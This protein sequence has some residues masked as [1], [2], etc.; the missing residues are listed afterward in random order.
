MNR[1][2]SIILIC[3]FILSGCG[4]AESDKKTVVTTV[5][6]PYDFVKQIAGDSID[7]K[8]L[9]KPGGDLHSYEPTPQDIKTISECDL[10]ICTGGENDSWAKNIIE[11]SENKNILTMM[12]CVD[13]IKD[14]HDN[15]ESYDEHV[16][17]SPENAIKISKKICEELCNIVPENA[18]FY[19]SN[20]DLYISKLNELDLKIQDITNNSKRLELIFADPF[21]M[22]YFAKKYDLECFSAFH[23]CSGEA[24]ADPKTVA[25]LIERINKDNIP[26]VLYGEFS[27]QT[28]ADTISDATGAEKMLFHSCHNLTK[29]DFASGKTYIDIMYENLDVLKEA[30]N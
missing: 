14:T 29:E 5:F 20:L 9:L 18:E 23:G 7:V 2:I 25:S 26:V 19:K 28:M 3:I 13:V 30:L 15:H 21:A 8:L 16:W 11:A 10:F 12:D 1:F 24:E 17:T 4:K 22:I 27:N 6:P